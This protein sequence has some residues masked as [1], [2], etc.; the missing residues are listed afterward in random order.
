[1]N[2][3]EQIANLQFRAWSNA[4]DQSNWRECWREALKLREGITTE[5]SIEADAIT[6]KLKQAWMNR[7]E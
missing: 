2:L 4:N 5:Q 3:V 6:A 7:E 1:M